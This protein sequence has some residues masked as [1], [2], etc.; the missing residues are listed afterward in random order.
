M[1]PSIME[2]A[3]APEISVNFYQTAWHNIP[4][5]CEIFLP[6]LYLHI[7]LCQSTQSATLHHHCG[8]GQHLKC[9]RNI[10]LTLLL[11]LGRPV[12]NNKKM[13]RGALVKC[14]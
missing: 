12:S 8:K 4:D 11:Q 1:F 7:L 14:D 2:A 13:T 10:A 6:S 3:V 5:D 9:S